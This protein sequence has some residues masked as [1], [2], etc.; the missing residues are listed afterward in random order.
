MRRSF[1]PVFYFTI[2]GEERFLKLL[3]INVMVSD[4]VVVQ[5]LYENSDS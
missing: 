1:Y 2:W 4:M 5:M 3:T